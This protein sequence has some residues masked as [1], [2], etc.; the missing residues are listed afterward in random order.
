MSYTLRTDKSWAET[1]R[2]V[3]DTFRKWGV[4]HFEILCALRGV[5]AQKWNQRPE[6][7]EVAINFIHP[8][9][10]ASVP[11]TSKLQDR[12]VDNFRVCYLALEAIRLNEARGIADVVREAYLSLPAPVRQRDPYEV[13]GVRSDTPLEDIEAMYRAKARR[14]HADVGGSDAAMKELNTA[15]ERIREERKVPA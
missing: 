10:G 1:E 9:S 2:S 6:E 12:A 5:Q 8:T 14:L 4:E 7:A 15:I 13:L 3:R 11:V